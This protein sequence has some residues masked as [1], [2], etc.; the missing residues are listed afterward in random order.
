MGRGPLV[1]FAAAL[2][3]LSAL[4]CADKDPALLEL[5]GQ[6][7]RRSEFDQ[8]LALV[9]ARDLGLLSPETKAGLLE[10]FLE[11][12][13]LVIEARRRGLL[14]AQA[15]PDQ[16]AEAVTRMVAQEVGIPP[17]SEEEITAWQQAHAAELVAPEKVSLRQ[18]LVATLNEARD[19]KRRLGKDPRTFDTV[20][21]AVSKG[22]EAAVGG[23]MGSFQRGELPPE[24]EAVAFSLPE[25]ATSEP[26]QSPL[27]YH[28][29]RVESRQEARPIPLEEARERI[30]DRLSREKRVAAERR[31][32]AQL[33]A[34]A[35]VNH[36]AALRLDRR[37]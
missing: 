32:V 27:G 16:E 5:D 29:L 31:F 20:A 2:A 9:E 33:M 21:R 11:E 8:R 36:E 30:H 10:A 25:G 6:R 7:V 35:K 17:V 19:V 24:L 15:T 37:P 18:V 14:A 3:L 12:R 1:Q 34:R 4:G 28:V 23:Y 26:I 22:P 13:A